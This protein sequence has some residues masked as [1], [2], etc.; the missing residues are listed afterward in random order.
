MIYLDK[1]A[2]FRFTKQLIKI[3]IAVLA[4]E[5][6]GIGNKAY[7]IKSKL[8]SITNKAHKRIMMA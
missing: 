7:V 6:I 4:N 2:C 8:S 1:S 5:P 3:A